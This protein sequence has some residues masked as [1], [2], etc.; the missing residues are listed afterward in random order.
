MTNNSIIFT[1]DFDR[2]LTIEELEERLGRKLKAYRRSYYQIHNRIIETE[3]DFRNFRFFL[4]ESLPA[5]LESFQ[6]DT[7][8]SISLIINKINESVVFRIVSPI[9]KNRKV[10]FAKDVEE[11]G[12]YFEIFGTSEDLEGDVDDYDFYF[13]FSKYGFSIVL[14]YKKG[15]FFKT[16]GCVPL[17]QIHSVKLRYVYEWNGRGVIDP[18]A[19]IY[20]FSLNE[21]KIE[22][23]SN[24]LKN[25][26]IS[27]EIIRDNIILI[28]DKEVDYIRMREMLSETIIADDN[29]SLFNRDLTYILQNMVKDQLIKIKVVPTEN[30][31]VRKIERYELTEKG[32][33][34]LSQLKKDRIKIE[35]VR[36]S[37]I[38]LPIGIKIA[39]LSSSR[40]RA[41]IFD[42]IQF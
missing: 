5:T 7:K 2:W 23:I 10:D 17:E 1:E 24:L 39:N 12:N 11:G 38:D 22:R 40:F 3:T 9:D 4:I 36:Y 35:D 28:L 37:S 32:K 16:Y 30:L 21:Y 18:E 14:D 6:L 42:L 19:K 29:L 25:E 13:V 8:Q 26:R 31:E 15:S 27:D 34:Y 20:S 41:R 33:E